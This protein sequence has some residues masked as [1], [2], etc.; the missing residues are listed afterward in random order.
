MFGDLKAEGENC[1]QGILF[2]LIMD[3]GVPLRKS[4]KTP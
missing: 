4:E 2:V 1:L 3:L